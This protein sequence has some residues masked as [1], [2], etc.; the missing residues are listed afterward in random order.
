M[1]FNITSFQ[2]IIIISLCF[3]IIK[4]SSTKISYRVNSFRA[5]KNY[6]DF[7]PFNITIEYIEHEGN[8][9][10]IKTNI[11]KMKQI[12]S[13]LP[14]IIS[15]LFLCREN[16]EIYYD[17]NVLKRMGI[18]LGSTQDFYF[19]NKKFKTDLLIII[20]FDKDTKNIISSKFFSYNGKYA[21]YTYGQRIYIAC[22]KINYLYNFN[23]NSNADEIF[24]MRIIQE[25]FKALGFRHKYLLKNFI[26]NKFEK[27]PLY[28]VS[29]SEI[30]KSYQKLLGFN[31]IMYP[32]NNSNNEIST[33][34]YTEYWNVL[35]FNFHDIMNFEVNLDYTISELT[36]K[37]FN[38]MNHI[39]LPKCDIFKFE[40]GVEKGFKCIRVQQ[41][42]VDKKLEKNYFLEYGIYN[43]TNI[44]CYLNT[45]ENIKKEQCGIKYG[46]LVYDDFYKYFTQSFKQ[47]KDTPLLAQREIPEIYLYKNQS[48]KLLKNSKTCPPGTP[49]N[50]FFQVPPNIFDGEKNNTNIT[51]L[52]NEL[53]EINNNVEYDEITLTEKDKKFFVTYEAYEDDYKRESVMKVLNFSG[54]IRSFSDYYTHNLLIKNPG[55]SKLE[56]IGYIPSLQ[57][58]FSYNNF[59]VIAYKDLTYKYYYLMQNKFPDDYT[60]MPDTYSYPEEKSEII[61]KFKN[62]KLSEDNLWLIKPK[63]GTLG[64]GIFIFHK[65]SDI[66]YDNIITKY[67]SYPH[68]INNLKYDFRSYVLITGLT[69]LKLYLY[70]EGLVRFTTEEYSLDLKKVDELYRHLTNVAIN[71]KNKNTYKKATNADTEEGSKWSMQVYKHYCEQNNID[72]NIIWDQ[73]KDI[74]I[75]S[76]LAVRDLFI[77]KIKENE[78]KD[79]NHFKLFGYDFLVDK[80]LKVYLIEINSRPS[81]LMGD[82]NDIKLKPQLIADTL[83]IVGITPYSHDYKDDFKAF[84]EEILDN[85]LNEDEESVNR[86]LCEFGRPRGRFELIFPLKNKVDYYKKF[87]GNFIK[88]DEMLWEKI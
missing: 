84:D 11:S 31:D 51:P 85:N 47:I 43:N 80:D 10:N 60:Y 49:R 62:Y 29:N 20:S 53:K 88:T 61:K 66:K 78:T 83:N 41:D 82:I 54:I 52:I 3:I 39:T 27:V 32:H 81:L 42:C 40:Q 58:I 14:H 7:H 30:Y 35:N 72:F 22:F 16:H 21:S 13:R 55:K 23:Y 38:E 73:M 24:M 76:I 5:K 74:T 6:E 57:K 12:I 4:S 56:D 33:E 68:L 25:T 71:K 75:K 37:V 44:K 8:N 9:V 26:K 28:L 15:Q 50:I 19:S 69:P 79:K 64:K 86:A 46:N 2:L 17:K 65:L 70:Q 63:K 87:Y 59:E 67:I 48:F 36:M 18:I 45:K 1:K 77:E 34:F